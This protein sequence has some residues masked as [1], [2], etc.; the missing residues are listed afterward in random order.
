MGFLGFGFRTF[1]QLP[2]LAYKAS[3]TFDRSTLIGWINTGALAFIAFFIV[4]FLMKKTVGREESYGAFLTKFGV[5]LAFTIGWAAIYGSIRELN[6]GMSETIA[7]SLAASGVQ[8]VTA[9]DISMDTFGSGEVRYF[10]SWSIIFGFFNM[11]LLLALSLVVYARNLFLY[12]IGYVIFALSSLML[13]GSHR[14]D[15][16]FTATDIMGKAY[17]KATE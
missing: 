15:D 4:F 9:K 2:E 8:G 13:V 7:S 16:V 10:T 17:A 12:G 11:L 6:D 1:D 14:R 5:V 3:D